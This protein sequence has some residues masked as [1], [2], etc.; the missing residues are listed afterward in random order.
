MHKQ[1]KINPEAQLEQ[2]Q[3]NMMIQRYQGGKVMPLPGSE[4]AQKTQPEEHV[5]MSQRPLVPSSEAIN[6]INEGEIRQ[7]DC[8][9]GYKGTASSFLVSGTGTRIWCIVLFLVF[10]PLFWLPYRMKSCKDQAF[11][12]PKCGAENT[13]KKVC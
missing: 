4:L 6:L 7:I 10:F 9:C 8:S 12:C 1:N 2:E 13:R 3:P 11:L 5:D